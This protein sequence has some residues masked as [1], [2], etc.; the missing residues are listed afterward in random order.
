MSY[1][2]IP[3]AQGSVEDAVL[4]RKDEKTGHGVSGL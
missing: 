1:I 4:K 3:G 2:D